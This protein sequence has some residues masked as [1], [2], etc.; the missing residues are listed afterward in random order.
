MGNGV[1]LVGNAS[2]IFKETN[3]ELQ[4]KIALI[5][6]TYR[7]NNYDIAILVIIS[8]ICLSILFSAK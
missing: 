8:A 7:L 2:I 1:S 4:E 3:Q 6:L 5:A